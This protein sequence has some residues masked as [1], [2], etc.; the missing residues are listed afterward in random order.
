MFTRDEFPRL[1]RPVRE[2]NLSE[3]T[4]SNPLQNTVPLHAHK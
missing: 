4:I 3:Q 2:A 1:N